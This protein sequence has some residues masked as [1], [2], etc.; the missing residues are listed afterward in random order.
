[1]AELMTELDG[2]QSALGA[3]AAEGA[4]LAASLKQVRWVA[5]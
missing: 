4:Q 2:S 1:V 5:G 3:A